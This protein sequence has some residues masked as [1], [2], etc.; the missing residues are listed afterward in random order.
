MC[1]TI[2]TDR[3]KTWISANH[4]TE[5]VSSGITIEHS[6]SIFKHEMIDLWEVFKETLDNSTMITTYTVF[7]VQQ[8]II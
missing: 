3:K 6:L 5:I 1:H 8:K 2:H 4:L 7:A